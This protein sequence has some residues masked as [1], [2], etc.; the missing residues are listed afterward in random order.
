MIVDLVEKKK[1][2][3]EEEEE[4]KEEI[5]DEV[6]DLSLLEPEQIDKGKMNVMKTFFQ[7]RKNRLVNF[8]KFSLYSYLK[9]GCIYSKI[10]FG[11]VRAIPV[12]AL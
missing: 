12:F 7:V 8:I 11:G 2:E 6:V 1:K 3:E 5:K 9:K 10:S 4:E